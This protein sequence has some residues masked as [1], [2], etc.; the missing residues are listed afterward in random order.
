MEIKPG[1]MCFLTNI[2]PGRAGHEHVGKIVEIIG[3]SHE[4]DIWNFIPI[5]NSE[6]KG[7]KVKVDRAP[8]K[9][10]RPIDSGPMDEMDL[11][12]TKELEHEH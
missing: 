3:P 8:T 7:T 5:L 10:L 9:Y 2:K 4:A 1:V 6:Y 12:S 11:W